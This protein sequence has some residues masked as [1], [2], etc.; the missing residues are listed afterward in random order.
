LLSIAPMQLQFFNAPNKSLCF[1][2]AAEPSLAAW[3]RVKAM[4]APWLVVLDKHGKA[5]GVLPAESLRNAMRHGP[6][7]VVAQLPYKG[8][9][10]L[11]RNSRLSELL[12][13]LE[14]PEIEAVLLVEGDAVHTVVTRQP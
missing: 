14:S 13:A 6:Q 11:P 10:V 9:A 5:T 12:K 4:H 8:A 7:G 2:S 1:A 3:T